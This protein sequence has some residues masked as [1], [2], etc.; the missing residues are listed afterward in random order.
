MVGIFHDEAAFGLPEDLV[1]ADGGHAPGADDLAQQV[2]GAHAGQLVGVAHHNDAAAV[3]QGRDQR[4]KQLDVH[5][6]HLV[7]NDHIALEQVLVVVDEADHAA[8]IVHLQ[9]AV[10]GAGLAAGELAQPFGGPARGGAQGHPLGL[11]FQQLQDGVHGGGLTGAGAAG[12]HQT[13]LGHGLA[14]GFPLQRRIG[15]ALGQFQHLQVPVQVTGGVLAPPGQNG[16]PVGNVL[17]GGQKVRQVDVG[18]AVEHLHAEFFGLDALVQRTGQLFRRLV[19]EVGG[20]FQQL[21][22]GQAGVAVARVVAQSAQQSGFQPLGAVAL[23][24]VILGDAVGVAEVQLQRLPAQQ[25]GVGRNRLHGPRPERPEHLHGL[26]GADLELCQIGDELPHAEHPL[27]LL[28]DAVGLVRRDAGHLSEPGGVVGNDLQRLGPEQVDDLVRRLGPD[29]GQRPAGKEGVHGFQILGHVRL[30]L[31]RVE[32][33]AIGGVVLVPAAADDALPGVQ[34][35][36]DAAHHGDDPA[37]GHLE[38]GVAVVGVLV[39]DIFHRAF[40]LFQLLLGH[41]LTSPVCIIIYSIA[42][43]GRF[44]N[45]EMGQKYGTRHGGAASRMRRC[46]RTELQVSPC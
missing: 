25:V 8:G 39:D 29:V 43:F 32:L 9:Q 10:D 17:L 20:G 24:V 38:H 12:E 42:F 18:H 1:E 46:S 31:L 23:H 26:A 14:D 15:K 16:Q 11:I 35:P 40:Q 33:P 13:V 34:L 36:H 41:V 28:L 27:E 45:R 2:A 21:G 4:L 5:H 37:A 7:Q 3:T 6:A 30:A 44:V 19:D 22:P